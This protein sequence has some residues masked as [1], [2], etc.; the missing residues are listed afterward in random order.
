[1]KK[2]ESYLVSRISKKDSRAHKRI[3]YTRYEI[4]TTRYEDCPEV[5]LEK[6]E[7]IRGRNGK[8]KFGAGY[9]HSFNKSSRVN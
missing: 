9:R 1:M 8:G 3:G 2:R 4:R 6:K 5:F 7:K